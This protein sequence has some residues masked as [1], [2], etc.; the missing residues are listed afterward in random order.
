[1]SQGG[2]ISAALL[3]LH[4]LLIDVLVGGWGNRSL[5]CDLYRA[6]PPMKVCCHYVITWAVLIT[7]SFILREMLRQPLAP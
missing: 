5:R 1:M 2:P 7:C 4:S 3:N 6:A